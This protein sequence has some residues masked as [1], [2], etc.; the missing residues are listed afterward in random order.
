[1]IERERERE[2]GTEKA[3]ATDRG[4]ARYRETQTE[5]RGLFA[6]FVTL[7]L[8]RVQRENRVGSNSGVSG[9]IRVQ[10]GQCRVHD[11]WGSWESRVKSRDAEGRCYWRHG[12]YVGFGVSACVGRGEDANRVEIQPAL[13]VEGRRTG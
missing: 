8:V 3:V 2:R 5:T 10:Q 12:I 9:L 7:S 13:Q 1:M 6:G 11:T 4:D